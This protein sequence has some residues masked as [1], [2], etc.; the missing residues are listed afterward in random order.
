MVGKNVGKIIGLEQEVVHTDNDN[1]VKLNMASGREKTL[2][3]IAVQSFLSGDSTIGGVVGLNTYDAENS[4]IGTVKNGFVQA[5]INAEETSNVGGVVGTNEQQSNDIT[6]NK[7]GENLSSIEN[8]LVEDFKNK[9]I[10]NIKS[11]S[12]IRA[13]NNVGGI[14]GNDVNGIYIEC[15]FQ[16]LIESVKKVLITGNENVGGIAGKSNNGKFAYCSVMSYWWNYANLKEEDK[17]N[18]ITDVADIH[19]VDYVGGIVG[20]A[21]SSADI[22]NE[23]G[24]F[25]INNRTIVFYSSVNAYLVAEK[26]FDGG[27]V[28]NIGGILS[29]DNTKNYKSDISG[30]KGS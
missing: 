22:L 30:E 13:K 3:Q 4:L 28:G 6:L 7:I 24:S 5:I 12:T 8:V 29:T 14:V 25:V 2:S 27:K 16:V 19:G 11:N 10:Y 15:D 23:T 21:I 17:S 9:S 26:E 1:E 20:F 18:V